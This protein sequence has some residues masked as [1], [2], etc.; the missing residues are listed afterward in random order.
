MLYV[1]VKRD[2]LMMGKMAAE[3]FRSKNNCFAVVGS[4]N[5]YI[6]HQLCSNAPAMIWPP[7]CEKV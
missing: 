7:S 4:K 3:M 5:F 6:S 2:S 1:S